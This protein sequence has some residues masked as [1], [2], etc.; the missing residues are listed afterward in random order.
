MTARPNF[1]AI[2]LLA[3]SFLPLF[4][5]PAPAAQTTAGAV[6]PA[7]AA[8]DLVEQARLTLED[9]RKDREFGSSRD[10]IRH[11]KAV[12]IIPTLIKGGFLLGG[13]GGSGVLLARNGA[14][15]SYPAFYH[16]ASASIG[17]QIGVEVS[18][19]VLFIMNDEALDALM[20]DGLKLGA[21]AGVAVATL[22][23]LAEAAITTA[24][25]TDIVAWSSSTGAYAGLALNGS[26][27]RPRDSYNAGYY[28]QLP[29]GRITP[30]AILRD[31]TAANPDADKLRQTLDS[32]R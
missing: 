12:L 4:S 2:A 6:R 18:E 20:S 10:L 17:L 25:G 16:M 26:L 5:L 31:G 14:G 21:Q 30:A 29:A 19:V 13:E 27:I 28:A 15:W 3:A 11:A 1:P 9:L 24:G 23:T 32:L 7:S 8:A 22:G